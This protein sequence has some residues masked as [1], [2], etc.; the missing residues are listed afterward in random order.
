LLP[1]PIRGKREGG[2]AEG[3]KERERKKK[4]GKNGFN[5]D[6]FPSIS[7]R[8]E[9]E[10]AKSEKKEARKEKRLGKKRKRKAEEVSP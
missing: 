8:K 1:T 7:I 4:E 6:H 3:V 9:R 2:E 10:D 5:C